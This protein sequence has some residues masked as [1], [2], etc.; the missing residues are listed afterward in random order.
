MVV[1]LNTWHW[2]WWAHSPE[3]R[4]QFSVWTS[5]SPDIANM[6]ATNQQ[7]YNTEPAYVEKCPQLLPK[8]KTKFVWEINVFCFNHINCRNC[9]LLHLIYPILSVIFQLAVT[10][11]DKDT[12]SMSMR[13]K[14]S[15]KTAL[16]EKREINE[17]KKLLYY[18]DYWSV[19][20]NHQ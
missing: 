12:S 11:N 15:W 13:D 10:D 2:D 6:D 1:E 18:R 4:I 9:L 5:V 16:L 20:W 3:G 14:I 19:Y 7:K 17:F 8:D